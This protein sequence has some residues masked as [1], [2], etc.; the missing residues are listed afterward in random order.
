VIRVPECIRFHRSY[1]WPPGA[2]AFLHS[3]KFDIMGMHD[4]LKATLFLKSSQP[5]MIGM[6]DD[7]VTVI[8]R[9]DFPQYP[10]SH[11]GIPKLK[12]G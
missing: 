12:F 3:L 9:P 2:A 1:Y 11:Q 4:K 10:S 6:F 8:L 5:A 7:D